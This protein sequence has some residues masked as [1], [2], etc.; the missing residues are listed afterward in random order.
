M[1]FEKKPESANYHN[2]HIAFS[3]SSTKPVWT[4]S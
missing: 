2:F 4:N 3:A 1:F